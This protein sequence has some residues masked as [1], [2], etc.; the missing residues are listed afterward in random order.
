MA[1]I[2]ISMIPAPKPKLVRPSVTLAEQKRRREVRCS[3]VL[4]IRLTT[5]SGEIIPAVVL[6][7]S[8]SGML[9]LVDERSSPFLPPPPGAS[10]FGEFFFDDIELPQFTLEVTRSTRRGKNQFVLGCRFVD[11]PA[12]AVADIRAKVLAFLSI[13]A[14][15]NAR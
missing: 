14:A 8:A 9:A 6:N 1:D 12:A 13:E 7:I 5:G 15:H 10:F 2:D 11:V 4:P 3:V